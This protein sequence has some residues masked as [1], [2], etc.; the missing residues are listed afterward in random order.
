[1]VYYKDHVHFHSII[2]SY[3]CVAA[4]VVLNGYVQNIDPSPWTTPVGP[5]NGLPQWTTLNFGRL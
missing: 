2:V 5:V 3:T 4:V 1:M